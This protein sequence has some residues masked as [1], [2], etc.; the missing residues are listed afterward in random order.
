M[1][2]ISFRNLRILA[3][4]VL[5]VSMTGV[6]VWEF[7]HATP[8]PSIGGGNEP[9]AVGP[10]T[11]FISL[12]GT[13]PVARA[14][15]GGL[16]VN[17]GFNVVGTSGQDVAVFL[18]NNIL[19]NTN[20]ATE[21]FSAQTFTVSS[22]INIYN[23][24]TRFVGSGNAG[25]LGLSTAAKGT[26][27]SLAN[28]VNNDV[29]KV[30][31]TNG[32]LNPNSLAV[33]NVW[34]DDIAIDG[35]KAG[36]SAGDCIHGFSWAGGGITHTTL[37]N[38]AGNG[39]ELSQASAGGSGSGCCLDISAN[40]IE[41][42]SRSCI[43]LAGTVYDF[44]HDNHMEQCNQYGVFVNT[45]K[46]RVSNNNIL[47][48]GY[49]GNGAVAY[50]GIYVAGSL[51]RITGNYLEGNWFDGIYTIASSTVITN[52]EIERSGVQNPG[53]FYDGIKLQSS[54]N[55]IMGNTISDGVIPHATHVAIEENGLNA[56][57][58]TIIGNWSGKL[59]A[60][61]YITT[62]TS[63]STWFSN[64]PYAAK[65]SL[66]IGASVY[67]LTNSNPYE[68]IVMLTSAGGISAMTYLGIAASTSL[69]IPYLLKT[70]QSMTFT[71]TTTAPVVELF[72]R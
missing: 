39:I 54:N 3:I 17:P 33:E 16:S 64:F 69:G 48:A 65:S 14:M 2:R 68:E 7:S 31:N 49:N 61:P 32:P 57:N 22:S 37:H 66:T 70:G 53:T 9:G 71:W 1:N 46:E 56:F 8:S 26:V 6:G 4:L 29:I 30:G 55:T 41:F 60:G 67:T 34:I 15:I 24:N 52:N 51:A 28:G 72:P 36:N 21:C 20:P 38:C 63:T 47:Q 42:N 19:S 43:L 44:V 50:A 59:Q 58:N 5:A 40:T 35:N 18:N 23:S 12:D 27:F 11:W 25:I 13:T 45:S 10:C 62:A